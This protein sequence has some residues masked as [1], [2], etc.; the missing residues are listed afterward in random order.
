MISCVKEGDLVYGLAASREEFLESVGIKYDLSL[1]LSNPTKPY[2]ID[3]FNEAI[4]N[5]DLFAKSRAVFDVTKYSHFERIRAFD[6]F[7]Q[8]TDP[9]IQA[10][11]VGG[12]T[13]IA[14]QEIA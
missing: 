13:L 10:L 5:I 1:G 4:V 6:A 7:C 3:S 11:S 8:E 2:V 12:S 9:Q 14:I